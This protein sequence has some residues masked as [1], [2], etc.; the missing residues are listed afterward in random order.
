[1]GALDAG[2]AL[3]LDGERL[4]GPGWALVPVPERRV[5]DGSRPTSTGTFRTGSSRDPLLLGPSIKFDHAGGDQN[6]W[7]TDDARS[8]AAHASVR[9]VVNELDP[10]G[11]LAVGAPPD[12]YDLEIPDL[13][14]LVLSPNPVTEDLVD[15]VWQRWFGDATQLTGTELLATMT[16]G[17]RKVQYGFALQAELPEAAAG[18]QQQKRRVSQR[19]QFMWDEPQEFGCADLERSGCVPSFTFAVLGALVEFAYREYQ[20]QKEKW[21]RRKR[22]PPTSS[23]GQ[24]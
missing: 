12:E 7:V 13:V 8:A 4:A 19:T 11:L 2:L 17:L 3:G 21:Q 10:I 24:R 14:E 22:P 18:G 15:E 9:A 6:G 1:M 23:H 5:R 20:W 16:E